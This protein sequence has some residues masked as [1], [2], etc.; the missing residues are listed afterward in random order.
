MQRHTYIIIYIYLAILLFSCN[1]GQ[2]ALLD[3]QGDTLQLHYAKNLTIV[4]FPNHIEVTMRNPWDTTNVLGKYV[5]YEELNP[6]R[7]K[8][9]GSRFKVPLEH[10]AVFSSVH[11]ALVHELHA[12]EAVGGICDFEFFN[13]PYYKKA[14]REGRIVNLGN[15]MQPSLE[16]MIDL[17]PDALLPSPFENS[18]GLGRIERLGIPIIWCAEYMEHTPLGRAEWIRFYGRLF[19]R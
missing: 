14:V 17:S 2:T 4:T 7:F 6:S 18:G 10:A 1:G 8:D 19:G 12:D 16:K 13:L 11:C 15:S 3:E 5:L 9:Q